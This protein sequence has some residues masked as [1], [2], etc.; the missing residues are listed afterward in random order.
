M[1]HSESQFIGGFSNPEFSDVAKV[2]VVRSRLI[3]TKPSASIR[4]ENGEKIAGLRPPLPPKM[5]K[6]PPKPPKLSLN[7]TSNDLSSQILTSSSMK[8]PLRLSLPRSRTPTNFDLNNNLI[9]NGTTHNLNGFLSLS[10]NSSIQSN[11][12]FRSTSPSLSQCSTSSF[13]SRRSLRSLTPRRIFPQTY[14]PSK[15]I[16]LSEL[17]SLDSASTVFDGKLTFML[18]AN[19]QRVHQQFRSSAAHLSDAETASRYLSDKISDFLKRTDHINEEWNNHCKSASSSRRSCDV[20]SLIEEQRDDAIA[21]R[22]ARSK[23]VTN[24]MI[25]A[26]KMVQN[27]PPTERASSMCRERCGSVLSVTTNG[28]NDTVVDDE[29]IINFI[30]CAINGSH[31]STSRSLSMRRNMTCRKS[32]CQLKY[33]TFCTIF[34]VSKISYDTF[35]YYKMMCF[36]KA[37]FA[38]KILQTLHSSSV[39]PIVLFREYLYF[40]RSENGISAKAVFC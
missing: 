2:P 37:I 14:T 8:A 26:N 4:S 12:S 34:S 22:L 5:S 13:N 24:I 33:C 38:K 11:D 36:T 35:F 31:F 20:I 23:S 32:N 16:D 9:S 39:V 28:D 25:K 17:Q 21:K 40:F 10:R 18:D 29:V 3:P 1:P 6:L 15:T 7:G 27:L 19:K 30:M